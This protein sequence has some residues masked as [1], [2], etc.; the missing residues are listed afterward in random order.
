MPGWRRVHSAPKIINSC[1]CRCRSSCCCC[2]CCCC[3]SLH[4]QSRA[5]T[6]LLTRSPDP[7]CPFSPPAPPTPPSPPARSR[8]RSR[9]S[10]LWHEHKYKS[11]HSQQVH[12]FIHLSP[13]IPLSCC[14][15]TASIRISSSISSL[16][17]ASLHTFPFLFPESPFSPPHLHPHPHLPY[18]YIL[19]LS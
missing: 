19:F 18:G 15:R 5:R 4:R 12:P 3:Y 14:S 13:P 16:A 17:F 9:Q 1:R 7:V 8:S 6:C 11:S 2:C 10:P